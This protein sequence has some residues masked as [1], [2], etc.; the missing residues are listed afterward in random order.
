MQCN[1]VAPRDA[2]GFGNDKE[3]RSRS[4]LFIALGVAAARGLG[5]DGLI[6]PEN[7]L[8]SLNVPL[9]D[10]RVGSY[11]TRTTHPHFLSLLQDVL[12]TV[13]LAITLR[14]PYQFATKGEMLRDCA[15]QTHL[16]DGAAKTMSCAHATESHWT[17]GAPF[18]RHC[19]RCTACL[20]RRAAFAFAFGADATSYT[21]MDLTD[22]ELASN[23]AEGRDVRA[24]RM[25][26]QRVVQRPDLA[27]FLILKPGP[28]RGN[29]GR[30]AELYVRGMTELWRIV[31]NAQTR[32]AY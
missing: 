14:N 18:M 22:G 26:A 4:M 25:A 32:G 29:H 3:Q 15:I 2:F 27:Q 24:V 20:I 23:A 21:V 9:N 13:G 30:Y 28:L 12:D 31:Q 1:I 16:A 7:G 6:I 5:A 19:G 10:L 11:T 8:I 17:K